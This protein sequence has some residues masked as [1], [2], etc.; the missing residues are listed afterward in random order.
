MHNY[1][2]KKLIEAI[3]K[4]DE[5]PADSEAFSVW[6][7]SESHLDFLRQN[8]HS[9]DVVIYASGEYTFIHSVVVPDDRLA[10]VD[11]QDLMQWNF[12]PYTSIAS[13][14]MGGGRKDVWVERDLRGTGS[15]TLEDAVPLIFARTFEGWT[16]PGRTYYE[17]N[18]EYAH[19]TEIGRASCR[20]R[21]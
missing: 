19:L 7:K 13:Y 8:A 1:E 9:D 18:Q 16:G 5:P 11:Q 17:L 12:N 15:K 2:H 4:I 10:P 14:V 21:V 20:E 3:T 6:I